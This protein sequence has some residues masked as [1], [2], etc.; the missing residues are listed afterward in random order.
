[1]MNIAAPQQQFENLAD[2]YEHMVTLPFRR[3]IEIPAVMQSLGDITGLHVLDF[4]CGSGHYARLLKQHGAAR[5]VGFD[6]A[7]GMLDYA[8]RRETQEQLGIEYAADLP[9]A[10]DGQFDLV[11]GVYVLPY[12]TSRAKLSAMTDAMARL[13]KPGGRL[14]TLPL[15]PRYALPENY[16]APYGFSLSSAQP[17][18]DGGE[19]HLHLP[20]EHTPIDIT[21][22]YWSAPTLEQTL[23]QSGFANIRWSDPLPTGATANQQAQLRAYIEQPHTVLIDCNYAPEPKSTPAR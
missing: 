22:W 14:L 11:L 23:T 6:A 4:G 21:A 9:P 3:Q 8:R 7:G 16:Y 13:L 15:H 18:A 17:Y 19:V 12:A 5:V 2:E 10:F 20:S 1:M